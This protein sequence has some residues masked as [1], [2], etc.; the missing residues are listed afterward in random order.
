[1]PKEAN[2]II[3]LKALAIKAAAVVEEVVAVAL[4]ALLKEKA[5]LLL[6]SGPMV[7]LYFVCS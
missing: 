3:G 1:M 5:S 7:L 6:V 2:G 4:A